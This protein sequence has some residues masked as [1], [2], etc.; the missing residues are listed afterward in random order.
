MKG[1]RYLIKKSGM[2]THFN[3]RRDK[4]YSNQWTDMDITN[5]FSLT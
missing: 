3:I 4:L 1:W 2:P 5:A